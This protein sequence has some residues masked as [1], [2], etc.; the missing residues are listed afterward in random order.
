MSLSIPEVCTRL[1][2]SRS[3]A[4]RWL[5][6]GKLAGTKRHP[7]G[8]QCTAPATCQQGTWEIDPAALTTVR[9]ARRRVS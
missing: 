6:A 1:N 9:R 4:K 7:C 8:A 3:T 5:Q 2:I